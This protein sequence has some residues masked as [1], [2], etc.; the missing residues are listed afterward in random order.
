M[1]NPAKTDLLAALAVILA[2]APTFAPAAEAAQ[3]DPQP[4]TLRRPAPN[5]DANW[6]AASAGARRTPDADPLHANDWQCRPDSVHP[7][8]VILVHGTWQNAYI[9]WNGLAPILAA[10][11]YCVFTVNYGNTTGK[12]GLNATGDL[13]S[14][15]REIASFV[16]KVR[17]ATSAEH[18]AL[19]GH[20]QGGAQIRYYANLLAPAG[21]VTKV[22]ALTASNHP[23]TLSNLAILGEKLGIKDYVFGRL[24]S[25]QMPGAVQQA[26]PESRFYVHLN[27]RGET[28]PGIAY[29]NIATRLD[30]VVTPW[31]GAFI[32]P[33]PGDTVDNIALQDVCKNDLSDH[34]SVTYSKNVA[35][36]VLNK[37]DPGHPHRINCFFQ[38]PVIGSTRQ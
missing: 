20:S 4:W 28:R 33:E 14:S 26:Q 22:I 12:P 9:T 7:E 11:G 15:A 8:P 16:A 38:E 19:I 3:E 27:G 31:T 35:Q 29:T 25:A 36:I 30:E 5:E 2:L 23:T 34:A 17:K 18:V 10:H 1:R 21:E 32:V 6:P 13:I 37:L 24:S